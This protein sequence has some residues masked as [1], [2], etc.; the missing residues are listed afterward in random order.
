[1][2]FDQSARLKGDSAVQAQPPR[3]DAATA[4]PQGDLTAT[5]PPH[6]HGAAAP[7][8]GDLTATAPPRPRVL[9]RRVM[10][11][12][13]PV[14]GGACVAVQSMLSCPT[15]DV[16][17]CLA[18]IDELAAAGCEIVRVAVPDA[19]SIKA[20]ASICSHSPL[21]V[22]ADIHFD[23]RLAV[24]A[25]ASGAAKLRINPGNIGSKA[26]LDAVIEAAGEQGIPIRIGV[27][28]GSLERRV[29]ERGDLSHPEKLA[30]SAIGFI[31]RFRERGFDDIVVSAKAHDVA[32]TLEA[33]RLLSSAAPGVP[34]HL[35]VTEAGTLL[36]GSVK[37]ALGIG[38]L[39]M[40]GI[41]DTIRVSLTAPPAMEVQAAWDILAA[42][43]LR[44]R[45]PELISCPTC[46]RCQVDLMP[47]ASAVDEMLRKMAA[48]ISVAV[49]GCVVNGPGEARAADVGVA[50]GK[51]RAAVFSHGEV[52]YTVDEQ[53]ILAALSKEIGRVIAQGA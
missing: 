22:V 45:A 41:G 30:L 9:T 6:A 47:I 36:R 38:I 33:Y 51:G 52:L 7:P 1:M 48:P 43:G 21:P 13:V 15:Q 27:N 23:H 3:S 4:P 24:Q 12:G 35:G 16:K 17:A 44:R 20:F 53:D 39:L 10:V 11:G 46:G 2:G 18:A 31:E 50:C 37:S 32:T 42:I 8:W 34:L 19:A 28:A 40:E 29:A 26:N 14:G 49:M 25:A 5:A